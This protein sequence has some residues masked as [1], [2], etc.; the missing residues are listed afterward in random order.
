MQLAFVVD[1][2]RFSTVPLADDDVMRL[3]RSRRQYAS[4]A[5][6]PI[7]ALAQDDLADRADER[8]IGCD[9]QFVMQPA[10]GGAR[11][12]PL[13]IDAVVDDEGFRLRQTL[14]DVII[15]RRPRDGQ[16]SAVPVQ[17]RH[18]AAAQF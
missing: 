1:R 18:R 4:G 15:A 6:H 8:H 5:G 2:F 3:K 10:R 17:V 9:P 14:G 11:M 16:Q 12:E 13:E 7:Q